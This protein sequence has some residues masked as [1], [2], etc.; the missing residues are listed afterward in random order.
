MNY[1]ECDECGMLID[2]NNAYRFN[3]DHAVCCSL[4]PDNIDDPPQYG[5]SSL[6]EFE[7]SRWY[8]DS[9]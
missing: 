9:L 3:Y 1:S 8:E 6:N 5:G 7:L 2:D 4:H